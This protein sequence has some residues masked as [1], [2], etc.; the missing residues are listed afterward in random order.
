V[1]HPVFISP[2][3]PCRKRLTEAG[4]GFIL[5]EEK[6]NQQVRGYFTRAAIIT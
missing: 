6:I 1:Q 3:T 5:L 4:E 2:N